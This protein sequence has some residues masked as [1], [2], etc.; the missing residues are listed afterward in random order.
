MTLVSLTTVVA[1]EVVGAVL[2]V[3]FLIIP[4]ATA[5]LVTTRLKSMLFWSSLFGIISVV[6]GYY[7]AIL[8]NVSITGAMVSTSGLM[9]FIVL[10]FVRYTKV[11][12]RDLIIE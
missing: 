3:G 12:K 5:Q 1:F 2:V 4:P 7:I 10:F 8:L 11:T 9:F 6:I